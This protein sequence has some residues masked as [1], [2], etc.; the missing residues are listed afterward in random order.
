MPL[1]DVYMT[2]IG[3][4]RTHQDFMQQLEKL[5]NLFQQNDLRF[6]EEAAINLIQACKEHKFKAHTAT[7]SNTLV[8]CTASFSTT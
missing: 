4:Y 8:C 3:H 5:L 6:N 2:Y 7:I 1:N